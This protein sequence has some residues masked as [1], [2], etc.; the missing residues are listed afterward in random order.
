MNFDLLL[1]IPAVISMVCT[2]F[3][4]NHYQYLKGRQFSEYKMEY[5]LMFLIGIIDIGA[6]IITFIVFNVFFVAH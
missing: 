3:I 6:Y 4:Y 5:F 2:I 1:F